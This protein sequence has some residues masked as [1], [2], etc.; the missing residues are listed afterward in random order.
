[1][2]K[3]FFLL[4]FTLFLLRGQAHAQNCD[5]LRPN[6]SLNYSSYCNAPAT[7]TVT[8]PA[9][10][11]VTYMFRLDGVPSATNTWQNITA[12]RHTLGYSA[13]NGCNW[14]DTVITLVSNPLQFVAEQQ[15]FASC[16]DTL[17]TYKLTVI[18]GQPPYRFSVNEGATTTNNVLVLPRGGYAITVIDAVGCRSQNGY[19][20]ILPRR[21][22]VRATTTFKQNSPCDTSATLTISVN[23]PQVT[24]P[25]T[26]SV[27]GRP[28]T[29]DTVFQNIS[30]RSQIS[31][32]LRSAQGCLYYGTP[33]IVG[34]TF[35]LQ[36][37]FS[38]FCANRFGRGSISIAAYG[39]AAPYKYTW[40]DAPLDI[41]VLNNLPIGTYN[42][43]V[44]DANGCKIS[45][46]TTLT[47]CVWAGD[48]DT[49]GVV[50]A[51]DL[52]NIGLAFGERG[53]V[54]PFCAIDSANGRGFCTDWFEQNVPFWSKQTPDGVNYKHIDA[55][56]NGLI[57]HADTLA[58]I[59]NWSKTRT[60]RGDNPVV[61]RGAA[62]PIS[63][64]TG[65]VAEGQWAAFPIILGDV[66]NTAKDIY[67]LAFS[68]NYD[69][70]VIDASSVYLSFGQNWLGSG[71]N[72]LRVFKN[73]NGTIET[74]I[75]RTNLQNSSGNGQIA[76]LNFK[77]KAGMSGRNL[78]F[79]IDNQQVINKDAQTVPTLGQTTTTTVLTSTSEPDWANQIAVYPNPTTGKVI[80]EAQN[81]D[82]KSVEVF[83]ISGKSLFKTENSGKNDPLS[84]KHA[85]TYF[86]KI[87]TANG[88]LMRKVV[89]L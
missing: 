62:P 35:P 74:A 32:V 39:G 56:G 25:F 7:V 85:G 45:G 52:L 44:T 6:Y 31:Y 17:F 71:D 66:T 63:V 78:S 79:T 13:S 47:T 38:N 16:A 81:I 42:V 48:T 4:L 11:G 73:F 80:V 57:N 60:L 55:N 58:I 8:Y 27:N 28:F 24:R 36:M 21:D 9:V 50:N 1:M 77:T 64:Q 53:G 43:T 37:N 76:T 34:R 70:S 5:S 69:P 54:R 46:S 59:K 68:I 15:P 20:N 75:S 30:V 26:I 29:S 86:L 2:P 23:D 19:L 51:A 40:T 87:Q 82:V 49:S 72:V 22:S 88:V 67:G 89:K 10:R 3:S 61:L 18:G 83:D 12:G 84:I 41:S 33:Y 14:A 65:R